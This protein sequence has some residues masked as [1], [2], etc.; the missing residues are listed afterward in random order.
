MPKYAQV[1]AS[2][3]AQIAEGLLLPKEPNLYDQVPGHSCQFERANVLINIHCSRDEE[4]SMKAGDLLN[5]R[6]RLIDLLGRGGTSEV[7]RGHDIELE[8]SIAIKILRY[9]N[10]AEPDSLERFRREATIGAR[11]QHPGITVVHDIGQAQGLMFIVMEL[12][13]GAELS[14]TL[15]KD[16]EGLSASRVLNLGIQMADA[17]A[18]AHATRVIHR[19]VKPANLFVQAGDKLKIL[20]FGISTLSTAPSLEKEGSIYGTPAYMAPELWRGELV[21]A[22]VDLY[23]MGCVIY[24]MLTG[25]RPFDFSTSIQELMNQHLNVVPTVPTAHVPLPEPLIDLT[26]GLLA[27]D[28]AERPESALAVVRA[29]E[30]I[31]DR[32]SAVTVTVRDPMSG[33]NDSGGTT[34]SVGA[35]NNP[36]GEDAVGLIF[37][38]YVPSDRLYAAELDKFLSLFR[39]WLSGV[40]GH[41]IR[42]D[43]Y[44]TRAGKVYEFYLTEGSDDIDLDRERA[45][46]SEFLALCLTDPPAAASRLIREG[47]G[48][49]E[50]ASFASRYGR[51]IRR[52]NLDLKQ[53]RE[54]RILEVWHGIEYD[55]IDSDTYSEAV[56]RQLRGLLEGLIP[57]LSADAYR[58]ILE[59]GRWSGQAVIEININQQVID[60]VEGAVIQNVSG[61]VNLGPRAQDL[62]KLID[63][64]GGAATGSLRTALH[65]VEDRDAPS[66]R[67]HDAKKKLMTFLCQ[68]GEIAKDVAVDVLEKYLESKVG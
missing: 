68:V 45:D 52:L 8:R 54:R 64:Y 20:D 2:I 18:A 9:N 32:M 47:M 7:W 34:D 21:S 39:G 5:G 16:P 30:D 28:P 4:L 19:D 44:E 61:T 33:S 53:E 17:L 23:G 37:R 27:K 55:L 66:A 56:A 22:S 60:K 11:L 46:F 15:Q 65:E 57:D 1:A 12:L 36:S 40:R 43:G 41:G 63:D 3:R 10:Y 25:Q 24:E 50:A 67:R 59:A 49:S 29:L 6:Y 31:R 38:V 35:E 14:F 51:E 48:R 26:M 62:L 13:L 58:N 42:Q